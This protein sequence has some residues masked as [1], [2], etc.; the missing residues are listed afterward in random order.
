MMEIERVPGL[1]RQRPTFATTINEP[2]GIA[3]HL[4][5]AYDISAVVCLRQA[6][7]KEHVDRFV[8]A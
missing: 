1:V 8:C 3:T 5:F 6:P 4:T 7:D 2:D